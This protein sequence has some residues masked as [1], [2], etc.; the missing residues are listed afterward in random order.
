MNKKPTIIIVFLLLVAIPF[1]LWV[2]VPQ[3]TKLSN[4]FSYEAV[5]VSLDNFY[6]ETQQ[7]YSGEARSIT[8]FSYE[9]TEQKQGNLIVKNVFDV[10]KVTG[11]KIFVVERLYGIDP[12][13]GKHVAG[14]GDKTRDG[15]LFAPHNLKYGEPFTYWHINYD[16]PAHMTFAGEENLFGLPVYRYETRYEGVKIDQTT[17]LSFLPEV[18]VTRGVILEPYLQL[19][20]E[21]ISGRLIKY[22]DDTIAYYYDLKTDER[23]NPWNHFENRYDPESVIEQVEIARKE[24]F[25]IKIIKF[26]VPVLLILFSVIIILFQYHRNK[27]VKPEA[28]TIVR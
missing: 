14:F 13:T 1:W 24:N 2:V 28:V 15:Y 7:K 20:I 27:T 21:P 25:N 19:W 22:K 11:E 8:K 16:G 4:N 9:V 3:L 10:R 12:K 18:G 5:I 17:N 26:C 6:D 23:L